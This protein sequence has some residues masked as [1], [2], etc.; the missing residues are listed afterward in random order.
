[1]NKLSEVLLMVFYP[2]ACLFWWVWRK[3]REL[4]NPRVREEL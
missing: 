1:M 3:G 2:A 4:A